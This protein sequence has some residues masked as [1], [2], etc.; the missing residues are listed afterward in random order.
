M[1]KIWKLIFW[2][3]NLAFQILQIIILKVQL[4]Q[5]IWEI[6]IEFGQIEKAKN[7]ISKYLSF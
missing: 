1:L 7:D 2:N 3:M 4:R 6:Q 5:R